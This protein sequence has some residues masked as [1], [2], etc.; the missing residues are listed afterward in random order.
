M[1]ILTSS[2][3]SALAPHLLD[4]VKG[5]IPLITSRNK[6]VAK[7]D[8]REQAADALAVQ[9]A[10]LQEAAIKQAAAIKELA[11]ASDAAMRDLEQQLK[12]QKL[13]S[14]IALAVAAVSLALAVWGVAGGR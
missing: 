4:L 3:V 14:L 1:S 8:T 11:E 6:A 13:L 10:E 2:A 5:V 9:V 12:Q 7:T